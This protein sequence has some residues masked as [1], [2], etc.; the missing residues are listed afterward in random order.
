MET[1]LSKQI[2]TFKLTEDQEL[3]RKTIREVSEENFREKAI[4]CN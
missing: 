3:L 4:L 2:Q 1:L